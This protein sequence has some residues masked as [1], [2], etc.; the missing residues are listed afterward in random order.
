[1][2]NP[3]ILE[4]MLTVWEHPID[5]WLTMHSIQKWPSLVIKIYSRWVHSKV[6]AM[7]LQS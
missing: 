2:S 5:L 3:E 1:M 6:H 4:D 7:H